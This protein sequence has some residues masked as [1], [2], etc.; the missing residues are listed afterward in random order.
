M[1][2]RPLRSSDA[3]CGLELDGV[4][5]TVGDG[6]RV[7]LKPLR[8]RNRERGGGIEAAGQEDNCS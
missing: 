3:S 2:A 7:A 8:A 1:L 4:S 6:Q 5:L